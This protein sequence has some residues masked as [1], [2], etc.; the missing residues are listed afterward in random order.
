MLI[1]P[2]LSRMWKHPFHLDTFTSLSAA[3]T[4]YPHVRR[5]RR[6]WADAGRLVRRGRHI[7]RMHLTLS[8]RRMSAT[9][10]PELRDVAHVILS[11]HHQKGI[12]TPPSLWPRLVEDARALGLAQDVET[13]LLRELY[14]IV[15][16][17]YPTR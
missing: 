9:D 5:F 4:A 1:A 11:R 16:G 7:A 17:Q 2:A 10:I 13:A 8:S 14:C 12:S 6:V 15:F 3:H